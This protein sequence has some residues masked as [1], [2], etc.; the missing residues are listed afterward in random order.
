MIALTI[1]ALVIAT[2]MW[3]IVGVAIIKAIALFLGLEGTILLA[4][5]LS[6]PHDAIELARP[7]GFLKGLRWEFTEGR[8]WNYP[9]NYNRVFFGGGLLLLAL[10]FVLSAIPEHEIFRDSSTKEQSIL[11]SDSK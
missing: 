1:A 3:L 11:P 4:S 2:V 9:V 6:P 7:K 5:A 10:S 8:T